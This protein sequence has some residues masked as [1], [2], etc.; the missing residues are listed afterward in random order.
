MNTQW[1]VIARYRHRLFTIGVLVVSTL[2]S[3][4]QLIMRWI[5]TGEPMYHY[6][7]WDLFLAWI[8]FWIAVAIYGMHIRGCGNRTLL[9]MGL[10]WL[11]FFPNAP[12]L[13]TEFTH[14]GARHGKHAGRWWCDLVLIIG[15]A[16]N[17]LM[18]GLVS[19]LAIHSVLR[20][21]IGARRAL[22][23]TVGAIALG[24]FG[25]ALGRF[26][27]FNSWDVIGRPIALAA[28]IA[29]ELLRPFAHRTLFVATVLLFMFLS[30]AYA[31]I[32]ALAKMND[33]MR[34]IHEQTGES[35]ESC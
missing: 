17:G 9:A 23:I 27:R 24:S 33:D 15:F 5:V 3:L 25:V 4:A 34:V 30:L 16:W 8:P 14:L 18:L 7:V 20:D 13:L 22:R 2:V 35:A 10:V 26:D 11:L 6:L 1:D 28:G 12:Y 32:Y 31:V 19:L 29:D 21:R